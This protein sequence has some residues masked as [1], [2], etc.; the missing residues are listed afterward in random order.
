MQKKHKV[1]E[2]TAIEKNNKSQAPT[3]QA[4]APAPAAKAP[5][6][7]EAKA[8]KAPKE[9]KAP[10]GTRPKLPDAPTFHFDPQVDLKAALKIKDKDAWVPTSLFDKLMWMVAATRKF[11][12]DQAKAILMEQREKVG[13]SWW[14]PRMVDKYGN[15]TIE[16]ME[17]AG[18]AGSFKG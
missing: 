16:D 10:A 14:T 7:V 18:V 9:P 1:M 5:A 3:P 15:S 11:T 2:N 12:K 6:K 8:P 17:E 13:K 4:A